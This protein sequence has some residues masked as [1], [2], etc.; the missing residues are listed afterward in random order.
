MPALRAEGE[1]VERVLADDDRTGSPEATHR[2]GIAAGRRG[3]EQR[4]AGGRRDS[5]DLDVVLDRDRDPVQRTLQLGGVEP[6]GLAQRRLGLETDEGVEPRVE[7]L[8]PAELPLEEL[9][10]RELAAADPRGG[11]GE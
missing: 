8:D 6:V 9:A 1:L 11:F 5:L 7:Q 2:L 10:C 4:G 3:I